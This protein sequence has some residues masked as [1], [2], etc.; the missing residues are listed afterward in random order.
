MLHLLAYNRLGVL[1]GIIAFG[2]TIVGFFGQVGVSI[3]SLFRFVVFLGVLVGV[4]VGIALLIVLLVKRENPL[5]NQSIHSHS[6]TIPVEN[7]SRIGLVDGDRKLAVEFTHEGTTKTMTL[8]F[9]SGMEDERERLVSAL[10]DYA[11]NV[12]EPRENTAP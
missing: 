11:E 10:E 7:I 8:H 5:K 12:D 6:R 4:A 3:Q 1:I 2:F 9:L